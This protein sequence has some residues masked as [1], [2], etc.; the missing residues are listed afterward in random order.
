MTP[1]RKGPMA[2]PLA[3]GPRVQPDA[4]I[5]S[6]RTPNFEQTLAF[7]GALLGEPERVEPRQWAAF[8]LPGCRLIVWSG[9]GAEVSHGNALQLCLQVA[10][11]DQAHTAL[12]SLA[13][14]LPIREAS[15][16]RE[17]FFSDPD[18]NE[19]VLYEPNQ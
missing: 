14:P 17:L 6:L 3:G 16:G 15:H 10:N 19:I 18:G 2:K 8:G 11:L 13:A 9:P 1:S 5:F 7:Y 4:A 12:G